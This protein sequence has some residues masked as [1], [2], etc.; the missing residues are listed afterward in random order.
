MVEQSVSTLARRAAAAGAVRQTQAQRRASSREALL[1]SA[2]RGLSRHGY[3]NLVLEEVARDA[4]YTR[5]ALYHQFANKEELTLAV[6]QWVERTWWAEMRKAV[7][8]NDDPAAGLVAVARAH[9]VYCRRDIAR[10]MIALRVE[11]SDRDHPIGLAVALA[12]ERVVAQTAK[13]ISAGRRQ[14]S[15]P[16]GAPPTVLASAIVGAVEG[17]VISLT[18]KAPFDVHLA[19]RVAA[20]LLGLQYEEPSSR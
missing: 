19:E 5:G 12:V 15:L 13:L 20:C 9:A 1:A 3:A 17:L 8:A 18:G 4:G 6:V 2:A 16:P 14:G 11:F 7:P 10:V